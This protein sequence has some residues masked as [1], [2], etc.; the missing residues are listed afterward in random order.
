[1]HPWS[2]WRMYIHTVHRYR[3]DVASQMALSL[4]C[5]LEHCIRN[6]DSLV[7]DNVII[8]GLHWVVVS[9]YLLTAFVYEYGALLKRIAV[10]VIEQLIRM[11]LARW[12]PQNSTGSVLL[13]KMRT[14]RCAAWAK[15]GWPSRRRTLRRCCRRAWLEEHE[16]T[17]YC[18]L[19]IKIER[20]YAAEFDGAAQVGA[21]LVVGGDL[22][23]RQQDRHWRGGLAILWMLTEELLLGIKICTW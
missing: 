17:R 6:T 22:C 4:Q 21:L 8:S 14:F 5:G 18:W 10:I 16:D 13:S 15:K 9:R 20:L 2:H 7:W 1:M 3:H 11:A 12:E 23:A 19:W